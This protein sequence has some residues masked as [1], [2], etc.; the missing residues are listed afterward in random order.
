MESKAPSGTA[1]AVPFSPPLEAGENNLKL[2]DNAW[3]VLKGASY[4]DCSTIIALPTPTEFIHGKVESAIDSLMKPMNQKIGGPIRATESLPLEKIA[5]SG[6]EV[7]DAYNKV[8]SMIESSGDLSTW[9]FLLTV[10]HDNLPPPDGL[11]K[12]VARMY[13][14]AKKDEEGRVLKDENGIPQFDF[15]GI[16][17]LYW[18]KGFG[19]G[20][21]MIYGNPK[22]FPVNF[23]PQVPIIGELQECRGIA[24]GFSIWNLTALLKDERLRDGQ[25]WF[26][27]RCSW[28]PATGASMG[29][30]DLVFCQK[31]L[32]AGYRFAVDNSVLVG[33]YDFN[34][35]VIF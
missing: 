17:G 1:P 25:K 24:M 29:T 23:R 10:E 3:R 11:V 6:F 34:T 7:A 28:D 27:T 32:E 13:E 20:M 35:G 12:L 19:T 21:P 22:E 31:A 15:L 26:Q 14:N 8:L 9:R 33:H 18:T 5:A 4:R 16:G 2:E 30:Q